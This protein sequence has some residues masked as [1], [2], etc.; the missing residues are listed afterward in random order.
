M[1]I[2]K[3]LYDRVSNLTWT[4]YEGIEKGEKVYV[5]EEVIE[6]MLLDLIVEI[7]RLKEKYEDL[8]NDVE[9]NYKRIPVKD[10][11]GDLYE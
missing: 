2:K 6:S 3:D 7:D 1:K 5:E 4:D 8:E 10:Q 11:I 9:E